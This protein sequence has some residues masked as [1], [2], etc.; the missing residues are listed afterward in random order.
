MSVTYRHKQVTEVTTGIVYSP[1]SSLGF[2]W[3][4]RSQLRLSVTDFMVHPLPP[5]PFSP[6][7]LFLPCGGFFSETAK[8]K[9]L[10]PGIV[11]WALLMDM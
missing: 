2:I 5:P 9:M 10:A 6:L 7:S 11:Q 8:S 4:I 3:V 1:L